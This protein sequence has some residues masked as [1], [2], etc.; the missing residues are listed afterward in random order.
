M[1]KAYYATKPCGCTVAAVVDV[2]GE[3]KETARIVAGYIR[4]GYKVELHEC[5]SVKFS[6]CKC[7]GVR[8]A[9]ERK[10]ERI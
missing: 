2:P 10:E 7:A 4:S 9:A 3:E 5:G 6:R 1:S 8:A